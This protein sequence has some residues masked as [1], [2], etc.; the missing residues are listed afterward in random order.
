MIK[1]NKPQSTFFSIGRFLGVIS[2]HNCIDA[3]CTLAL[4][5]ATLFGALCHTA[6]EDLVALALDRLFASSIHSVSRT[7]ASEIENRKRKGF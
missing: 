5:N 7:R 2:T 3:H 1:T 4:G 6:R